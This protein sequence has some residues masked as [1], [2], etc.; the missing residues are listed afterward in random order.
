MHVLFSDFAASPKKSLPFSNLISLII[1]KIVA[2]TPK[3]KEL[4]LKITNH[5]G[6]TV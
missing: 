4:L 6:I 1:G 3:T 2:S 5:F